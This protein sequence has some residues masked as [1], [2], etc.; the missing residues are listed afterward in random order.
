MSTMIGH[1]KALKKEAE[2]EYAVGNFFAGESLMEQY[3]DQKQDY[4]V[5]RQKMAGQDFATAQKAVHHMMA[6]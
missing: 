5:T 6:A 1:L 3:L 4:T 2:A